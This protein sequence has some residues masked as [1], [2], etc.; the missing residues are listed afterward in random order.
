MKNL[1]N[2]K[3]IYWVI[4]F[5]SIELLTSKQNITAQSLIICI[6]RKKNKHQHDLGASILIFD[7]IICNM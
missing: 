4:T 7:F 3:N 1:S 6:C 2:Y 5:H